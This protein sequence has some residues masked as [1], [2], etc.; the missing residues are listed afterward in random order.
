MKIES[1]FNILRFINRL[2]NKLFF[3]KKKQNNSREIKY[4]YLNKKIIIFGGGTGYGFEIAKYIFLNGGDVILISK[5][6][7]ITKSKK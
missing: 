2:V 7:K 5:N 3:K 4:K 1:R 6:K